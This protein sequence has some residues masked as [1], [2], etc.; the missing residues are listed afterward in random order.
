MTTEELKKLDKKFAEAVNTG[1][2]AA[3]DSV[4]EEIYANEWIM[5]NP[6]YPDLP[7]SQDGLKQWIR[8]IFG[9]IFLISKSMWKMS[10]QRINKVVTRVFLTGTNASSKEPFKMHCFHMSRYADKKLVEEW[11][12][13]F[14][15]PQPLTA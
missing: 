13:D 8:Q 9:W 7:H 3:I 15:V 11:E 10:L 2:L 12:V 4:I 14:L 6:T 5:H 1:D